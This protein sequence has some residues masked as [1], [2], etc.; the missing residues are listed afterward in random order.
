[1]AIKLTNKGKYE[2]EK[3]SFTGGR[4]FQR[5][6][7]NFIVSSILIFKYGNA[8]SSVKNWTTAY[9]IRNGKAAHFDKNNSD[10]IVSLEELFL[11]VE[12][13]SYF[14]NTKN[15]KEVNFSKGLKARTI[16]ESIQQAL[17]SD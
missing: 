4:R 5:L 12:F 16:D 9:K 2:I 6:D 8:N 7:T 1:N 11:L 17:K 15:E 13:I 10:S 3:T 14:I